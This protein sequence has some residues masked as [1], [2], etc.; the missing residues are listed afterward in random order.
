MSESRVTKVRAAMI[1]FIFQ[2]FN[3]IPTLSAAE[4]VEAALVPLGISAAQPRSRASE[5]LSD[6]G[7]GERL[8][9]LPSERH[10]ATSTKTPGTR[11]SPR[12]R[13]SGATAA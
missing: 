3:L 5:A 7:L 2:T 1:G 9:Y 4:N 12:W 11:S 13:T 8:R 6:V 10:P